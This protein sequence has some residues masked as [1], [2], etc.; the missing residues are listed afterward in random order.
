MYQTV[1][2]NQFVDKF[3]WSD[4]QKALFDKC[5]LFRKT[6]NGRTIFSD[7]WVETIIRDLRVWLGKKSSGKNMLSLFFRAS[8][9]LDERKEMRMQGRAVKKGDDDGED[10]AGIR[11]NKF[12]L[13]SLCVAI[14]MNLFGVGDPCIVESKPTN[15][16]SDDPV[17]TIKPGSLTCA[18]DKMINPEF[19]LVYSTGRERSKDYFNTFHKEGNPDVANRSE[20]E[21]DG[22]VPMPQ[23]P[24]LTDKQEEKD[25]ILVQR[26][27]STDHDFLNKRSI[28]TKG[29]VIEELEYL[30]KALTAQ[31]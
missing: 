12:F 23:I 17:V 20:W 1:L 13:E 18:P 27:E 30:N 3:V 10:A 16:R 8:M 24:G 6:V 15:K 9:L 2:S 4:A 19:L 31:D 28:Y 26:L 29:E 21:E 5:V 11:L 7:R 22:G 25:G 14:D